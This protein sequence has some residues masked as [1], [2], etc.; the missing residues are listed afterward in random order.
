MAFRYCI[1]G[2]VGS[3]CYRARERST[4]HSIGRPKFQPTIEYIHPDLRN[5]LLSVASVGDEINS[6]RLGKWLGFNQGRIAKGLRVVRS[7]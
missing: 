6:K 5:V 7:G 4:H 2:S 3:G 1:R